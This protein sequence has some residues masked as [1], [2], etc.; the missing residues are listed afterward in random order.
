MNSTV[1]AELGIQL[2][3]AHEESTVPLTATLTYCADDPYAVSLSFH[4]GL[5]EPV[6]WV[7]GRELLFAGSRSPQGLGDVQVWPSAATDGLTAS[8]LNIEL[9]S[10]SGHAHFEVPA[11]EL[12]DFL[13]RTD[14]IVPAGSES[15]HLVFDAELTA[16]LTASA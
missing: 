9:S 5:D 3:V 7:I 6:R 15:A 12:A 2:V 16:L 14:E 10:P 11:A 8:V 13:R 1:S 4:S